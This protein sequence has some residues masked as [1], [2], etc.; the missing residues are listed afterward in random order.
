MIRKLATLGVAIAAMGLTTLG[1]TPA[2]ADPCDHPGHGN[3]PFCTPPPPPP[4]P[5]P[6]GFNIILGSRHNDRLVGT[7]GRD[8]IF[9][10]G[11]RRDVIIGRGGRDRLYGMRGHDVIRAVDGQRDVVNGGS[12]RD[13]CVVDAIDV[14]RNCETI[15]VR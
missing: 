1:S 8:A 2:H 15:I 3:P 14:V 7:A 9:G 6:T 12:G 11:G 13:R 4:V 10:F 5:V